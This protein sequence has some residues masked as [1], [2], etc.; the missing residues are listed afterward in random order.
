[1]DK[2]K[3]Y[4]FALTAVD[5]GGSESEPVYST[6]SPGSVVNISRRPPSGK[7]LKVIR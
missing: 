3:A 7:I 4:R 5:D 6:S 1:M 2:T